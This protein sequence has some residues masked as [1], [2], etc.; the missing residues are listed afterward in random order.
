ALLALHPLLVYYSLVPYQEGPMLLGLL[1]GAHALLARRENRASLWLGLACLCRYEAWI[2]AALAAAA[3]RRGWLVAA[4]RYGWAPAAWVLIWRGLSPS[5]SYVLDLDP[6]AGRLARLSFLFAK[7]REYSGDALLLLALVGLVL[8]AW[9]R[10]RRWAW[11]GA[12]LASFTL[13]VVAAGHEFPPGS[14]LVSERLAHVPAVALCALAGAAL[15][16]S[17][18]DLSRWR[19]VIAA[20]AVALIG[21]PAVRRAQ[22]QV[23]EANRDPSLQLAVAVARRAGLELRAGDALA[24]AAPPVPAAALDDYVRK[25]QRVGGDPARARALALALAGRSPDATRIAAQLA[26]PPATVVEAGTPAALVAV[27]DDAP[28]A[29]RWR[30]GTALARYAAGPRAVTLYRP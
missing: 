8:V 3:R 28:E 25:I 26:R 14:G 4:L 12:Y 1:L 16:A 30:T 27:Y 9:R 18:G 21:V 23:L 19:W 5:G 2:A 13:V 17:G 29:A 7:L 15:G 6:T 10:D 24:V 11:G 20:A 22:A